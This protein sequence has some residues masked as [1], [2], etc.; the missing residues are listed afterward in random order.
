MKSNWKRVGVFAGLI[1]LVGVVA[2]GTVAFAQDADDE[3]NWPFNF[4]QKVQ[5]AIADVLGIS[6]DE[7]DT[8]IE[9]A[10]G[11]LLEEAVAEDV[12]TQEQA[13]Q[14]LERME[15]GFGFKSMPFGRGRRGHKM[16][17]WMGGP[18]NSLI[19]VA[20]E[21]LGLT[22]EDLLA[23][24]Q[25]GKT[26]A[27][28]AGQHGVGAQT[29]ADGFITI[30]TE[31]LDEAVAEGRITQEQADEMLAHMTEEVADHLNE[32]FHEGH[33]PGGC[34]DELHGGFWRGGHRGGGMGRFG[35]FSGQGK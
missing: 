7:Y 35:G 2:L 9:T 29:I 25:D 26:I 33:G 10:H 19:S 12:L 5:E 4:R 30:R 15:G 17:G 1:A 11:Q 24:L 31:K 23:E 8:A 28:V 21:Q 32:P 18:E 13:D 6:V 20:A 27:D 16:G 3:K 22:V 14:I 34:R